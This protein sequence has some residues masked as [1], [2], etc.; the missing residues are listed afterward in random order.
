MDNHKNNE[1]RILIV[2]DNPTNVDVLL[3]YLQNVGFEISIAESGLRALKLCQHELPNLIL[4]DM[5]MPGLDG[6][7]TCRRLKAN[8]KTQNIPIIFM[9]A[10]SDT[11]SK[12]NA[13]QSGAVDYVTKPIQVEEVLARIQTHLSIQTLQQSLQQE[14][15]VRDELIVELDAFA[16]TVAHDIAGTI[17]TII[18]SADLLL[19]K[20]HFETGEWK[21]LNR[22][23]S[24]GKK[25]VSIVNELLLLASVRKEQV[26]IQPIAM[27]KVILEAE[28]RLSHPL[29]KNNVNLI[30]PENWPLAMG[31]APWV[32]EV[33]MNYLSNGIK[34]GGESP[35]LEV[36]AD[37]DLNNMVRFWVRDNGPGIEPEIKKQLFS[38]FARSDTHRLLGHGLGLSIV[39]RIIKKLGGKVGVESQVGQGSTF[40]F[41]LPSLEAGNLPN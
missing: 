16:H 34:Y 12:V 15:V 9:T 18:L 5:M 29:A 24:S 13:F 20:E 32:E 22:I 17:T 11:V 38:E 14:I 30:I 4:L 21:Y 3:D 1:A 19:A 6:L 35:H 33:W 26:S 31:Y 10:I 40:Y 2:D 41:T 28:N 27:K 39:G 23:K 36:G 37:Q 7:E 25:T 8:P